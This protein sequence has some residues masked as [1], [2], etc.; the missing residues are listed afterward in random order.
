MTSVEKRRSSRKNGSR[1]KHSNGGYRSTSR[2]GSFVDETDREVS[3]LTDRAFRS[4][5]IGEE[6]VYN[7]SDLCSSSPAIQRDRQQAF[8]QNI[9]QRQRELMMRR[10]G[11]ENFSVR[12][13]QY[14]QDWIQ[15]GMYGPQ[16]QQNPQW[17]VYRDNTT[18]GTV[19]AT[20]QNSCIEMSQ[21]EK[22]PK[23]GQL[24]FLTNG[25]TELSLQQ[26]RSHSRVSSLIKAFDSE[27]HRDGTGM[28]GKY[29]E[30]SDEPSWDKSALMSIQRDLSE[31]STSYQQNFNSGPFPSAGQF[32][33]PDTNF[34]SAEVATAV[35]HMNATSSY[36]RSSHARHSMSAHVNSNFFMHSEFSPFKT[37]RDHNRFPF[38]HGQM[39]GFMYC[40]EFPKWYETPMYK[41]LS[42]EAQPKAPSRPRRNTMPPIAPPAPPRAISTSSTLQ[43]PSSLEKRCE[44]E[45][46]GHY[47]HWKQTQ[48]LGTN[49]LPLQR[50]ST[51]SPNTAVSQSV[52]DTISSITALQQ[53]IAMMTTEPNIAVAP[54]T[55]QQAAVCNDNLIPPMCNEAAVVQNIVSGNTNATPFNISQLVTPLIHAPQ[56]AET[57]AVQQCTVSPQPVEHP[58]V[59]AESRS[60]TP[61]VRMSSYRSR[62]TNLL[63]NLKDNRKRVKSTYSPSKFKGLEMQEKNKQHVIQESTDVVIDIPDFP[64]LKEAESTWKYAISHQHLKQYHNPKL[65]FTGLNSQTATGQN[66]GYTQSDYQTAQVQGETFRHSGFTGFI[67]EN[68]SNNQLANGQNL[69]EDLSSFAP[70]KQRVPDKVE[71]LGGDVCKLKPL[72]T[73]PD[74]LRQNN[75]KN[76]QIKESLMSTANAEQH[77]NETNGWAFSKADR[78]QQLKE[79]KHNYNNAPLQEWCRLQVSAGNTNKQDTE[80]QGAKTTPKEEIPALMGK[81]E[82]ANLKF[83]LKEELSSPTDRNKGEHQPVM[84]A[85]DENIQVAAAVTKKVESCDKKVSPNTLNQV[86]QRIPPVLKENMAY[87]GQKQTGVSKDRHADL[88]EYYGLREEN[89]IKENNLIQKY[90]I[91]QQPFTGKGDKIIPTQKTD[92]R[93]D[94]PT[95]KDSEVQNP[96]QNEMRQSEHNLQMTSLSVADKATVLATVQQMKDR[97]RNE[98][99]TEAT[100]TEQIK[101]LAKVQHQ[102]KP[103]A[104]SAMLNIT[105]PE[106]NTAKETRSDPE[107]TSETQ[108]EFSEREQPRGRRKGEE[109][110]ERFRGKEPDQQ[111]DGEKKAEQKRIQKETVEL[112]NLMEIAGAEKVRKELQIRAEQA[113]VKRLKEE[114]TK[115]EAEKNKQAG[116]EC[117]QTEET[118]TAKVERQAQQIR[119][120]SEENKK[121]EALTQNAT[122]T[123][124][125]TKDE[126]KTANVVEVEK[127]KVDDVK[128]HK[129]E[130]DLI[131]TPQ[132]HEE[133]G[134]SER[135]INKT[136]E[137]KTEESLKESKAEPFK[138]D[139]RKTERVQEASVQTVAKVILTEP[140]KSGPDK[141]A[142]VKTELA[143]AKAELAKIKEKMRGEQKV[144]NTFLPNED[145]NTN[146]DISLKGN[147]NQSKDTKDQTDASQMAQRQEH[148]GVSKYNHVQPDR[149]ADDYERLREK[150]GFGNTRAMNKIKVSAAFSN[151]NKAPDVSA[152]GEAASVMKITDDAPKSSSPGTAK[153]E[154]IQ[155]TGSVQDNE[156]TESQYIYS[157]SSKEFKLSTNADKTTDRSGIVDKVKHD[158]VEDQDKCEISQK[159]DSNLAKQV[160]LERKS[161]SSDHSLISSKDQHFTPL[162]MFPHK[163]RAQTKEEILT[164]KIKAHAEK[165]ISAIKEKRFAIRDGFLSKNSIKHLAGGQSINV[166]QRPSSQDASKRHEG[167]ACSNV[168]PKHQIEPSGVQTEPDK[169]FA[170]ST[171]AATATKSAATVSMLQDC[172]QIQAPTEPLK[173]KN[174]EPPT[175]AK[176]SRRLS[177]KPVQ[178]EI[179]LLNHNNEQA[180]EKQAVSY[181]EKCHRKE[182]GTVI[183][184]Q[185]QDPTQF[186]TKGKPEMASRAEIKQEKDQKATEPSPESDCLQIMGIMVTIR[187]RKPSVRDAQADKS[188]QVQ[189]KEGTEAEPSSGTEKDKENKSPKNSSN[190]FVV[191]TG[192]QIITQPKSS[193]NKRTQTEAPTESDHPHALTVPTKN[194]VSSETLPLLC[195]DEVK[196]KTEDDKYKTPDED[197]KKNNKNALVEMITEEK[198]QSKTQTE[199]LEAEV[200]NMGTKCLHASNADDY[201]SLIKHDVQQMG[202]GDMTK[203]VTN[204]YKSSSSDGQSAPL[205]EENRN[206]TTLS[207]PSNKNNLYQHQSEHAGKINPRDDNL[208]IDSI[209]IKV[210]P[211]ETQKDN[212]RMVENDHIMNTAAGLKA[213]NEQEQH[214]T[215]VDHVNN[216]HVIPVSSEKGRKES[217]EDKQEVRKESESSK[218][219]DSNN[220]VI[221]SSGDGKA[222]NRTSD[223]E[224]KL[225][226]AVDES[227]PTEEDYFQVQGVRGASGSGNVGQVSDAP[228]QRMGLSGAPPNKT[229]I[230]TESSMELIPEVISLVERK[231]TVDTFSE[232]VHQE[233]VTRKTR[234]INNNASL[235]PSDSPSERQ[236]DKCDVDLGQAIKKQKVENQSG[237]YANRRQSK[238]TPRE[239]TAPETPEDKPKPKERVT[240]IPEISA[241]ADYARLKVIVSE[242]RENEFQEFPPNK[243]EGFFPLIQTRHSRCPVF[244]TDVK[245]VSVKQKNPPNKVEV[246]VNKKPKAI[247]FST[248]E[249]EHRQTGMFK[250]GEKGGQEKMSPHVEDNKVDFDPGAQQDLK[251]KSPTA[252][253]KSEEAQAVTQS[254]HQ[255]TN[256]LAHSQTSSSDKPRKSLQQSLDSVS[257]QEKPAELPQRDKEILHVDKLSHQRVA[258]MP[259]CKMDRHTTTP[260]KDATGE[261]R[262]HT[263]ASTEQEE[264]RETWHEETTEKHR[265]E[266]QEEKKGREKEKER[267]RSR[268][269]QAENDRRAAQREE[270]RRAREREAAAAKIKERREKQ[271]EEEIKAKEERK[272]KQVEEEKK[273]REREEKRRIREAEEKRTKVLEEERRR[274]QVEE[275]ERRRKQVV[276]EER[277]RKQVVEE[278]RRRKQVEEEERRRKHV[279]EQMRAKLR[280]EESRIKEFEKRRQV[281]QMEERRA[282]REEEQRRAENERQARQKEEEKRIQEIQERTKPTQSEEQRKDG[283]KREGW[284]ASKKADEEQ[285]A[286]EK[287]KTRRKQKEQQV[288]EIKKEGLLQEEET[289]AAQ[290][291]ILSQGDGEA[292]KKEEEKLEQTEEEQASTIE[293]QRGA[294]QRMDVL[295]YY[296]I[297]TEEEKK[298]KNKPSPSQ[299]I[300]NILGLES[301]EDFGSGSRPHRPY[302]PVSPAPPTPCRSNNSSPALGVKP[303]MF[304]VKDNTIRGSSL[305]KSIKPR[306]YKNFGEDSRP[307]S[308]L[309]LDKGEEDQE[310]LR[311]SIG[312]PVHPDIVSPG[313]NRQSA[314]K[315]SPTR[316]SGSSSKVYS[317]LLPQHRPYSRRSI[318]VDEDNSRSVF[319]NM[320]EG[321]ETF[322]TS[323]TD[324]ADVRG[325]Y[326]YDRPESACSFSSDAS[327]SLGKPPAVPPK[328]EKALRRAQRLTTRRMKKESLSKAATESPPGDDKNLLTASGVPYSSTEV[329]SSN[330]HIMAS[331]HCS[332]PVSLA[333]AP[334]LGSSLSS[335]H[336]EQQSPHSSFYAS[337]HAAAPVSLPVVLPHA[338]GAIFTPIASPHAAAPIALPVASPHVTGPVSQPVVPKT[339]THV[340]SSPT[341]HQTNQSAPVTQYQVESSY[342]HSFPL[343]QRKVLQDLGSGQYFV[344]DMPVPVK[345]KMFYD[346]ET[347]KYVQL[348]VR[349]SVQS[350]TRAQSQH[351]HIQPHPQMQVTQLQQS[352]SQ[353]SPAGKPVVLS[354]NYQHPYPHPAAVSKMPPH[355][356]PSGMSPPAAP[357]QDPRL[358]G[359]SH[360]YR[361]QAPEMG[362]NSEEHTPYMDT[363]NDKDKTHN[364]VYNTHGSYESF[365]ERDTNSQL[366][367]SAVC[368][369]DNSAHS[370]Y[371]PRSIITMRELE[372][373]MDVSDW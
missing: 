328:S 329:R 164:S 16:I 29:R 189:P 52:L 232:K 207:Q 147:I 178:S 142:Q 337:H 108:A 318:A 283:Q 263:A 5:C 171:S 170:H 127:I 144:R 57:S 246:K 205:L 229:I 235:K 300:N 355:R 134:K 133:Q 82:H 341:L 349:E 323:A 220:D 332:P 307:G 105:E 22:S 188:T 264:I 70:N 347:G 277:R 254:I 287:E 10:E 135:K 285:Q 107:M 250:L 311:H 24:S 39:S 75:E 36:M 45:L 43:K 365:P 150:Y 89:N 303:S 299:Q 44:S 352:I 338:T 193:Q 94:A 227:Q 265:E 95:L 112:R 213:A 115:N 19:S 80:M 316:P 222:E 197:L 312:T 209:A 97:Q 104:E 302:T 251:H 72:H 324:M 28:D 56:E 13:Q 366:A 372:D 340:P 140:I 342:G 173:G 359:E 151:D 180:E 40:S 15:G 23:E 161:K 73:A 11:E 123:P 30:W 114:H 353:T 166:R 271:R 261:K 48:H 308:S 253:F 215:S 258:S 238:R 247:V 186:N 106:Q 321:V 25:A 176:C 168:T 208:H 139:L 314:L 255:I 267:E 91:N 200:L 351:A 181:G 268:V 198:N 313:F 306:F 71:I 326:E 274:K 156:V 98:V 233:N 225:G 130:G 58:P 240:T 116:T 120:E 146:K 110:T 262:Q 126:H 295:Q 121:A 158:S 122:T 278:E 241:I 118:K 343:T 196:N 320:S 192:E 333:H 167:A 38:Q 245:E 242:D 190:Q 125:K 128:E 84:N 163:D 348:N 124:E 85:K 184:A 90:N 275:E 325:L 286:A 248:M 17:G 9:Q 42:L 26:R 216:E 153:A 270:E 370:R 46:V 371:R 214:E 69:H 185:K 288:K 294:A 297:T 327:R 219:T 322:V 113:V 293:E 103:E 257:S 194:K 76:N 6:A 41:E 331:P 172:L 62:A 154:K 279:E 65:S 354:Q 4:L 335:F 32:S 49:R 298:P 157:E 362:Q 212:L 152:E 177:S 1:R 155:D 14:G 79:N 87:Y 289:R 182:D 345:T 346:P 249:K 159:S 202:V 149:G 237:L 117:N 162:R 55:N 256:P 223:E 305:T 290:A 169:S 350:G 357:P 230:D 34:Q 276:E 266:E 228:P 367:R 319:S 50:P 315:E 282:A 259:T 96:Q 20:F 280:E 304:R 344:V 3:S 204:S 183:N 260:Q 77:F 187:E 51:V 92:Q 358:A 78:S 244:T 199:N 141:V 201:G 27:G 99:K 129:V 243:K 221:A 100:N 145:F 218:T 143:K 224:K 364:P 60:V 339:V 330:C 31:F 284:T 88:Q 272:A 7:D 239:N 68:Y 102:E 310:V 165:E 8:G 138:G 363:V 64:D 369:N 206:N 301:A 47:P 119:Q 33:S 93:K 12:L 132:K 74:T 356:S 66:S 63:F 61:D 160:V 211:A 203:T 236:S 360:I 252:H 148:T 111:S 292:Q 334:A 309:E 179:K 175:E 59:R 174:T 54:A 137:P 373:F 53:G 269:S 231:K 86:P 217:L 368:E 291:Q 83:V 361:Y 210:V 2:G 18:P 81:Q 136:K 317:A 226:P 35:A 281:K 67:P 37:W 296:A 131:P 191:I 109:N 101:D 234:G 195:G 21:Q 336:A 273:A